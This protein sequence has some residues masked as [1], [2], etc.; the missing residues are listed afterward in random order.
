MER[1]AQRLGTRPGEVLPQLEPKLPSS[2]TTDAVAFSLAIDRTCA[3]MAE[4]RGADASAAPRRARTRP[5]RRQPAETIDVSYRM[6]YSAPSRCM[7]IRAHPEVLDD[8]FT[9]PARFTLR[10]AVF[11]TSLLQSNDG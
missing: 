9:R 8:C 3:P 4:P 5:Y 1:L 7:V 6:P 11:V 2:T 10:N